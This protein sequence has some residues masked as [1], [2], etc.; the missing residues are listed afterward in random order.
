MPTYTIQIPWGMSN[1]HTIHAS[2]ADTK[3]H[4]KVVGFS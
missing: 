1:R 2:F 3:E 4:Y